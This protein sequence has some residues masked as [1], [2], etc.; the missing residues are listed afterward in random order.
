MEGGG[1]VLYGSGWSSKLRVGLNGEFLQG[2]K[3]SLEQGLSC[4]LAK[5][6]VAAQL[7]R[8]V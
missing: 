4:D 5:F 2:R 8:R 1:A 6:A 7:F 3:V